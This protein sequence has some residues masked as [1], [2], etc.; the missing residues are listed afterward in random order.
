MLFIL[1][2]EYSKTLPMISKYLLPITTANTSEVNF[3]EADNPNGYFYEYYNT[4]S[5]LTFVILGYYG[6]RTNKKIQKVILYNMMILVGLLSAYYH[7]VI[8]ELSHIMDIVSITMILLTSRYTIE[9]SPYILKGPQEDYNIGIKYGFTM[10]LYTFFAFTSPVLHIAM[11]FYE[12]FKLKQ[13]IEDKIMS[14]RLEE[15]LSKTD[16]DNMSRKYM[17]CRL[18]FIFGL[19][20]WFFDHFLCEWLFGYHMHWI[21]HITIAFMSYGLIGLLDY[22]YKD[23]N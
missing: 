23:Q 3:C 21:F 12:G 19:I 16:I 8:S 18:L 13:L 7:A 1:Y 6:I 10:M 2:Y 17:I 5:S 9:R 15:T 14:F 22:F 11:E 20:M 4:M